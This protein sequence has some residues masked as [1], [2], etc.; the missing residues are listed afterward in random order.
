M[1]EM[2]SYSHDEFFDMSFHHGQLFHWVF[3]LFLRVKRWSAFGTFGNFWGYGTDT[4]NVHQT[5]PTN[6]FARFLSW[7][8]KS[9]SLGGKIWKI[10]WENII[11]V[12]IADICQIF[13]ASNQLEISKK[14]LRL[15]CLKLKKPALSAPQTCRLLEENKHSI[16]KNHSMILICLYKQ[17]I[18]LLK[19]ANLRCTLRI[20][21]N[22]FWIFYTF[23]NN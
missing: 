21:L 4:V 13:E 10:C 8:R 1:T 20:L 9:S 2:R 12:L 16:S 17:H 6:E 18:F 14:I 11:F 5:P 23:Y 22:N 15:D 7:R 3:K 19:Y